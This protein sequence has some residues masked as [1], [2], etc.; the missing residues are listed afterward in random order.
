MGLWRPSGPVPGT[1][2]RPER[3]ASQSG[4]VVEVTAN[5]STD[6]YFLADPQCER[7][8]YL[9]ARKL[10]PHLKKCRKLSL[11]LSIVFQIFNCIH[12]NTGTLGDPA[13]MMGV[14][15]IT[16]GVP[17]IMLGVSAITAGVQYK[18]RLAGPF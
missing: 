6:N 10:F 17:A 16:L 11:K 4:G 7:Q 3:V 5:S 12:N 14:P 8:A 13:F 1:H 2:R 18:Y 15:A 9:T